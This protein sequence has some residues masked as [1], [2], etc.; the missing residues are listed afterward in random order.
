VVTVISKGYT[1]TICSVEVKTETLCLS[2][3]LVTTH[4]ITWCCN[5]Q[6][7]NVNFH[8]QESLRSQYVIG[9][10]HPLCNLKYYTV[11]FVEILRK[12]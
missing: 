1:A 9:K 6:H 8:C 3:T 4:H 7:H 10:E 12:L 11:I 5:L 2:V